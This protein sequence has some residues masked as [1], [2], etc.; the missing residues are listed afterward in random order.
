MA[1]SLEIRSPYL[2]HEL[3]EFSK[4]L[5]RNLKVNHKTKEILRLIHKKYYPANLQ[6]VKKGFSVNLKKIILIDLR[7]WSEQLLSKENLK[8]HEYFNEYK[9]EEI[10]KNY[11][12]ESCEISNTFMWNILVMQNWILKNNQASLR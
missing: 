11:K 12:E 1:N 7:D 6:F 10:W 5:P 9:I 4:K 2:N 3:V 8:K